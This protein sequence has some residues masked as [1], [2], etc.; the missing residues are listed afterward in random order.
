M[1]L[2]ATV[3]V[4]CMNM[5]M[6]LEFRS[7]VVFESGCRSSADDAVCG[8]WTVLLDR[9]VDVRQRKRPVFHAM[10]VMG[11]VQGLGPG[12]FAGSHKHDMAN[13]VHTKSP[14]FFKYIVMF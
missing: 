3:R 6:E 14:H 2:K 5:S 11:H 13:T 10:V 4:L 12:L 8:A 7:E 9:A 1:Y